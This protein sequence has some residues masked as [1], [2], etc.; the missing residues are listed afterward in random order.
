VPVAV[1][2]RLAV[3]RSYDRWIAEPDAP[4][5][6]FHQLRIACKRLRYTF[7]FFR[8]ILGDSVKQ[9]IR[10]MKT[11]QDHL[12]ALQDAAVACSVVHNF[13]TWGSWHPPKKRC[14][15]GNGSTVPI[16]APGV[17]TYLASRQQTIKDLLEAF[18]EVWDRLR[19]KEFSNMVLDA[20]TPL[21]L[22]ED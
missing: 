11:Q 1:Y 21:H 8:E 2:E 18:P 15:A 22:S 13:L 16:I 10:E 20:L 4:L 7:E 6:L 3:V 9:L 12:G 17:A 5:V 14:E 19:G